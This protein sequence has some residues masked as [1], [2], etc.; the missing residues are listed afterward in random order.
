MK[1]NHKSRLIRQMTIFLI[2]FIAV[3]IV[4]SLLVGKALEVNIEDFWGNR[5]KL[6][7]ATLILGSASIIL[8]AHFGAKFLTTPILT[9]DEWTRGERKSIP[10]ELPIVRRI[11]RLGKIF[12]GNEY[13]TRERKR[14]DP[15]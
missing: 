6:P 12:A 15:G 13:G 8:F 9:L 4:V 5:V 3:S 11:G 1:K 7:L 14:L 2:F 10:K